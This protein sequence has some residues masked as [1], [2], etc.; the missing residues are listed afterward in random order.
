MQHLEP[1]SPV[2]LGFYGGTGAVTG[3][4]FL[5]SGKETRVLID[6]GLIQGEKF[7]LEMNREPFPYD[8]AS[9]DFLL[10]THA[11]IDHIG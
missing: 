8:P 9:I 2:T 3:A 7:V 11:H 1:R 4:N 5:L 10:V 6:C